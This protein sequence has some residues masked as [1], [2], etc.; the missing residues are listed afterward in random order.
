[1]FLYRS[2]IRG[3]GS[4]LPQNRLTNADIE[5]MVDTSDAWI[6][7]RTGISE[8]R[9]A[10]PGEATS[11]FA[12]EAA[13]KAM[14]QAGISAEDIEMVIVA[15]ETPDYLFPPVAVIVQHRLGLNKAGVMDIHA[16]CAGFI[17]AL[18]TADQYI[19]SGMYQNIL[20]IGA[21]T[22]SRFTDYTDRSTCILFA[23]GAGALVVSRSETEDIGIIHTAT[24][25]NGE[26]VQSLLIPSGGSLD[27]FNP[28]KEQK[29][30]MYMDGPKIF[31][32]AVSVMSE[33]AKEVLDKSG[34]SV[35]QVNFLIPHQANQRIIDAVAKNMDVPQEKVISNIK[36]VGNNSSATIPIAIDANMKAGKIKKGD[37]LLL[38]A[39]GAG[40]IW[41]GAL[42]K[43]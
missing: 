42:I 8:R 36:Y 21:D 14:D 38:V 12:T 35:D 23:D 5:K 16:T 22:L 40:L 30:T 17:T 18:Q 9:I 41:G 7:S 27:P 20:V 24:H 6:T 43:I 28:S 31:K 25:A 19:R 11:N 34:Y 33:T 32:L 26:H 13:K 29:T 15:T 10:S 1:M 39:F 4:H 37:T 2:I 3:I